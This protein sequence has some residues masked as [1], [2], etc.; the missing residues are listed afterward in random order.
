MVICWFCLAGVVHK[1]VVPN[2]CSK[3]PLTAQLQLASI[4]LS[5]TDGTEG[6]EADCGSELLPVADGTT[7]EARAAM[8]DVTWSATA[9]I[10]T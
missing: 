7:V 2:I 1:G 4:K 3:Q 9:H 10:T 5:S 8:P 6:M